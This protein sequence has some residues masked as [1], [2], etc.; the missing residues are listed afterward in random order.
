MVVARDLPNGK[1]CPEAFKVDKK[2]AVEYNG[3]QHYRFVP[4]VTGGA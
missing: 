2:L 3:P 4:E 1:V